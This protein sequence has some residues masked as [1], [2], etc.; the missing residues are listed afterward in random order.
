MQ[1]LMC[2]S[3]WFVTPKML[4]NLYNDERLDKEDLDKLINWRNVYKQHKGWSI[5]GWNIYNKDV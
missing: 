3:D 4:R 2:V 5:M 1:S